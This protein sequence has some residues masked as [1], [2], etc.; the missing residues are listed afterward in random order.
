MATQQ[1][2]LISIGADPIKFRTSLYVDDVM[3]FL[4]W[5]ASD[6]S[7][8][9][10]LLHQFGVAIRLCTNIQ[11]SEIFPVRCEGIDIPTVLGQFQVQ[12]GSLPSKYLGFPLWISTV[13]RV[14]KQVLIDKIAEKL[15]KWKGKLLNKTRRLTL[16]NSVLLAVVIYHMTAFPLSK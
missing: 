12:Q 4:R 15:P 10:H 13:K 9:Q 2:L 7:N 1:G 3:F 16:V 8:V 11:K 5:I 6:V 14:D